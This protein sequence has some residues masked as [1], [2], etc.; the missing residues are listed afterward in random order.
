MASQM[1]R[2]TLKTV[3][4]PQ[5]GNSKEGEM[6]LTIMRVHPQLDYLMRLSVTIGL[7]SIAGIL[8]ESTK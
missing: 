6:R 7:W 5:E 1:V 2:R 4:L 8:L 3:P